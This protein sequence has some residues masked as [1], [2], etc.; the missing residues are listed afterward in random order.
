MVRQGGLHDYALIRLLLTEKRSALT[1]AMGIWRAREDTFDC[2]FAPRTM[3]QGRT[4]SSHELSQMLE[5]FFGGPDSLAYI[6]SLEDY[7][8]TLAHAAPGELYP[9]LATALKMYGQCLTEPEIHEPEKPCDKWE[10]FIRRLLR[11]TADIHAVVPTRTDYECVRS[12]LSE[13]FYFND[14][15]FLSEIIRD[16]W[17]NILFTEGYDIVDYLKTEQ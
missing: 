17:L 11:N 16:A 12:P 8:W 3:L 1:H 5:G 2:T 7:A 6:L 4:I 13:L 10:S 9:A 15:V 14:D